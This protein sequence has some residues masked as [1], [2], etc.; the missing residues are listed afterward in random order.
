MLNTTH[1]LSWYGN[2]HKFYRKDFAYLK[3]LAYYKAFYFGDT[4]LDGILIT[5]EF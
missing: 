1:C 5:R 2:K 3:L 4:Y